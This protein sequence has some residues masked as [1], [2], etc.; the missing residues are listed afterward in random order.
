MAIV[1][2]LLAAVCNAMTTI[3]QRLGVQSAPE[4]SAF[5]LRLLLHVLTRPVWYLGMLSMVGGFALQAL[6]LGYG[7]LSVVQPLL[8]T[9]LVFLVVLLR[10]WF[11]KPLG[12]REAVGSVCTV[13]GLAIFLAVADQGQGNQHPSGG[14]WAWGVGACAGAVIL[15]CLLAIRGSR[16]WKSAC[17]GAAAA[18]AFALCAAFTKTATILF[19]QGFLQ[20]FGHW[21][22]YGIAAAGGA[23]LF[24]AQN[25]FYSGPITASQATLTIV[26]P[27]ASILLGVGLFGDRI[28]NAG[29]DPFLEGAALLV[30][31]IGLV[32]LCMSPLIVNSTS[33]ERLV[34][35]G[36]GEE[37][38]VGAP[39]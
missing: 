36:E 15:C 30:L 27:L 29:T 5:R 16:V 19:S 17:Y 34:P 26:D 25:A 22:T 10:I 24:L 23:G 39:A 37:A 21:Q 8:V 13:A 20:L 35:G 33:H 31:I 9:E 28:R 11:R 6:A 38:E 32:V 12:W 7:D 4:G 3:L 18:T 14:D 2:A 1:L